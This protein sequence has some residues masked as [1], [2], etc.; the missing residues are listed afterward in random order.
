MNPI[1]VYVHIPFCTIKCGYCDFNAYAGMNALQPAYRDALLREVESWRDVLA[2]REIATVGFGG[3]T[4]GEVPASHIASVLE[5]LRREAPFAAGAEVTLEANPGTTTLEQLRA[6]RAAGVTRMSFGAQ[7]FD[8]EELRFLDRI[9]SPEATGASIAL[10]R[11]AGFE[12]VNLDLIY[13]L[14]GQR[15]DAWE[16]TLRRAIELGTDHVSAYALTIEEG[17]PVAQR[18]E[19]GEVVPADPDLAAE[20]YERTGDLL[21][22]EGFEQYELSNWAKPGHASRHNQV[23]WTDGEYVGI[24]AGAHGYLGGDRYENIAHPRAYIAALTGDFAQGEHPAVVRRYTPDRVTAMSDWVMLALRRLEGF[25]PA[26]F[27]RKF[28]VPLD[29][30]VGPVLSECEAAGVVAR[31]GRVRLTRAGRQLHGEVAVRV[32]AHLE[33]AAAAA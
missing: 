28:G 22:A 17:T 30:A 16:R 8:A 7:S 20:M 15:L 25:E 18:V 12:S 1:S 27:E 4:P 11:E 3:G 32:L 23:Y 2:G 6:L 9:H 33:A 24:G 10:A 13:A 26:A 19:R 29:A 14:P 21:E 5:G 31:D